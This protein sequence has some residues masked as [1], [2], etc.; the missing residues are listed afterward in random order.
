[1]GPGRSFRTGSYGGRRFDADYGGSGSGSGGLHQPPVLTPSTD[2]HVYRRA[3]S[4]WITHLKNAA[5]NK[6]RQ[7]KTIRM[8]LV[9]A[10]R[11]KMS[12]DLQ[13]VVN[14]LNA[15]GVIDEDN[16]D[17]VKQEE[18]LRIVLD[19]VAFDTPTEAV[20]R[21]A[22]AFAKTHSCKRGA[23][24][25][26]STYVARFRG[27][28]SRYLS[29]S[30]LSP[31]SRESQLLALVMIENA[32]LDATTQANV[33]LQL[34]VM[35][36][37]T[38]QKNQETVVVP[39]VETIGKTELK[40]TVNAIK[41][42]LSLITDKIDEAEMAEPRT[43]D[44]E[45]EGSNSYNTH[46]AG[47]SNESSSSE[48]DAE[49]SSDKREEKSGRGQ[50]I[51]APSRAADVEDGV[52]LS[53]HESQSMINYLKKAS[54]FLSAPQPTTQATGETT[55]QF[56]VHSNAKSQGKYIQDDTV[57]FH[58]EHACSVLST[59]NVGNVARQSMS[60]N[61]IQNFMKSY[62]SNPQIQSSLMAGNGGGSTPGAGSSRG[63]SRGRRD[64]KMQEFKAKTKCRR[65]G[66]VG[67][68]K[69]DKE[70]E[71]A[72]AEIDV[73][74]DGDEPSSKRQRVHFQGDGEQDGGSGFPSA[75]R[76]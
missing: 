72:D 1:M 32:G 36:D 3:V 44:E 28:A 14:G 17:P 19:K 31:R 75:G 65:C 52:H 15:E 42:A 20:N 70:C 58:L 53:P 49:S 11:S 34:A 25:G 59:L 40:L 6:D 21:I 27:A 63:D 67:H 35:A 62:L 54:K 68:W 69:G 13:E 43:M 46:Q 41:K 71:A 38:S 4:T 51:R 61:E 56:S 48:S 33:K 26:I 37:E 76:K 74:K 60:K 7:A 5:E 64:R 24:E 8:E 47:G 45:S 29:L 9:S 57:F 50:Y 12:L 22:E 73:T 10:L 55:S 23:S 2:K 18:Y 30:K 66:K 39:Q 16:A